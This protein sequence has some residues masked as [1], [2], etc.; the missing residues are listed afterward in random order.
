VERNSENQIA[1]VY[2]EG[3]LLMVQVAL[4]AIA[5]PEYSAG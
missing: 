1:V 2:A 4:V 3:I 5:L